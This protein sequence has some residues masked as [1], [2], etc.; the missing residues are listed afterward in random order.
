VLEEEYTIGNPG[1]RQYHYQATW[2][3]DTVVRMEPLG[4]D[5]ETG[6]SDFDKLETPTFYGEA[7]PGRLYQREHMLADTE[8][9]LAPI[10]LD[11][12]ALDLWMIR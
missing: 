5:G 12:G 3:G 9:A 1:Y 10:Q 8:V 6:Y 11:D 2:K 7:G 4:N